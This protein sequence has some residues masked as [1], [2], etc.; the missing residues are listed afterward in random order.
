MSPHLQ[1]RFYL[2]LELENICPMEYLKLIVLEKFYVW[3]SASF[4][5][6]F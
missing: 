3:L 1:Q 6:P 4:F 2:V 5:Y